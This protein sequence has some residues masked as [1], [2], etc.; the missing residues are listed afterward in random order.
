MNEVTKQIV[1]SVGTLPV[2]WV[3]LKLIFR[4]SIMFNFSLITILFTI[5]VSITSKI[6]I[7]LGGNLQLF[8]TPINILVGIF[9]FMYINKV[10]RSPLEK[11]ILQVKELSEGNLNIKLERSALANELGILNNSLY[12]LTC[13][14][15][16]TISQISDNAGH[17]ASASQHVSNAADQLSHGANEQASSL[18]EI[19]STMEEITVNITQNTENAQHTEEMSLES[20]NDI[21]IIAERTEKAVKASQII[22]ERITIINDIAFQTNILA[23]NAA[24]EAAR[25][26]EYGRGFAVVSA[27][28]KKLADRSRNA[29][30]EIVKLARESCD[31]AQNAGEVMQETLP[32]I[33]SSTKL[34]KEITAASLEQNN[35]AN[36]VNSAIQQLNNVTQQNATASEE[37][38]GSAEQLTSQAVHL[39]ELI[40]FFKLNT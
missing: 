23:L 15:K 18:E 9:V 19:S 4:K 28:V 24:V 7:L 1:I 30:D 6:Q 8:L 25:A 38:S 35:G 17:L 10:L 32:K 13:V 5:F 21:Q 12:D 3:V 11:S 33:E 26:G 31:L 16:D 34:I 27:E 2:A 20:F 40:S 14:L 39:R 36:Q 29:A 22:T 37:L